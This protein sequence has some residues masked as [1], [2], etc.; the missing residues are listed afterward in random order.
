MKVFQPFV[1]KVERLEENE[2]H[3]AQTYEFLCFH[4]C[5]FTIRVLE[6]TLDLSS[7]QRKRLSK[8]KVTLVIENLFSFY[9]VFDLVLAE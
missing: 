4:V 3:F 1:L 7:H 6:S 8:I 5:D 9:R 2:T